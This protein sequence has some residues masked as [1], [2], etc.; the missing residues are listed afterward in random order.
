MPTKRLPS[1][2]S[3]DH[4]KSQAS[5]LLKLIATRNAEAIQRIREFHPRFREADDTTTAGSKLTLSDALFTISR[6]YGYRS[7]TSLKRTVENSRKSTKQHAHIP[8]HER[9]S[10]SVFSRAIEYLDSGDAN[11]LSSYLKRHP[12]LVREKVEF[13]GENYFRNPTL[14]EF[15]AENPIRQGSLPSNIKTVAQVI[16]D[17]GA[18]DMPVSVNSALELVVSGRI[19]RECS[20]QIPLIDLLCDYHADVNQAMSSALLHGEFAAT[21][22]LLKHGASLSLP[23]ASATGNLIAAKKKLSTSS[24]DQRHLAMALAT[25]H[26]HTD[27]LRLLLDAGENPN[28]YNPIGGHSHC[29]PLHQAAFFA[30]ESTISLL[31]E[32]GARTDVTDIIHKG[33]PLDWAIHAGHDQIAEL[34][35]SNGSKT[36]DHLVAET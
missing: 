20:V 1:N 16:L 28:R 31:L 6:E 29:Y 4:L 19:P 2:P 23:V 10:N 17:A 8:H 22:T 14:L 27:I 11:G 24:A 15:I 33:T 3:L 12:G 13:E 32:R 9:I 35:R 7:W 25:Q 34:L 30:H 5:D 18:K 36:A 21:E 26:G